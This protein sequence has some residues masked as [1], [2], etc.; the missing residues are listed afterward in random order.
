MDLNL[1]MNGTMARIYVGETL[2]L[3]FDTL[4]YMGVQSWIR[5]YFTIELYFTDAAPILLE[6]DSKE[7]WEKM[8]KI[9]DSI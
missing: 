5:D 3:A 7:K 8:L 9:I 4:N 6:Y 1:K 2:H